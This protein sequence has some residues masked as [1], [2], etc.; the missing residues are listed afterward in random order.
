MVNIGA[1]AVKEIK[2]VLNE[3]GKGIPFFG[4]LL[5]LCYVGHNVLVFEGH[6]SA[7]AAGVADAQLVI[8]DGAMIPF[9]QANW[10]EIILEQTPPPRIL[11]FGREGKIEEIVKK[12]S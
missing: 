12:I 7:L 2:G 10:A 8:V 11:V 4:Y 3:V 1:G 9:L 6:P 5:G